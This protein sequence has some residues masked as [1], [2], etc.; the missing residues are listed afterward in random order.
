[1]DVLVFGEHRDGQ[2]E[3]ITHQLAEKGR[4][5]A[6]PNGKVSVLILG[7]PDLAAAD[8]SLVGADTV[9]F[10]RHP[11]LASYNP[12]AAVKVA[13]EAV[14]HLK[15]P[16]FLCGHTFQGIEV[17]PWV[18]ARLGLPLLSN[19]FDLCREPAALVGRRP[20]YGQAWQVSV[21]APLETTVV[22]T[23][24]RAGANR[25]PDGPQP[26]VRSLEV[27]IDSLGIKT[28]LEATITPEPGS[29]DI[30]R[31]EVVVGVGRGI[32]D[33]ANLRLVE[34]LA[35]A[36]GGVLA[37]SRPLVDLEWMPHERQVGASGREINARV[38]IAC[39][40]SGAAQHLAGIRGVQ[41]VIAINKDARAPLF[42]VSHYGVVGDLFEVVP[43]LVEEAK[44]VRQL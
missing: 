10:V 8:L 22:A 16:L 29:E 32:R 23:L 5:L 39:G 31:A 6:G 25:R 30:G 11:A 33:P 37:C 3:P 1:V 19:C 14:R 44:R 2:L 27:D 4:E 26:E 13:A 21:R 38:Y 15:P 35:D 12:E 36:L 24:A 42:G 9:Q 43:A 41:T 28:T 17:A 7:G 18:A 40:I 34:E 20:V